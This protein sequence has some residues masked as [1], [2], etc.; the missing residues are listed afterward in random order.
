M[1]FWSGD[2]RILRFMVLPF[3]HFSL[4]FLAIWAQALIGLLSLAVSAGVSSASLQVLPDWKINP[5][6]ADH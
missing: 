4:I 6:P 3:T 2:H 5:E 1:P